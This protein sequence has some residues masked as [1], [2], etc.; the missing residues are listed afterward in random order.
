MPDCVQAR[1]EQSPCNER[2]LHSLRGQV[3]R[4]GPNQ[5]VVGHTIHQI[6]PRLSMQTKFLRVRCEFYFIYLFLHCLLPFSSMVE[7]CLA[8]LISCIHVGPSFYQLSD[9]RYVST[10]GR[11]YQSIGHLSLDRSYTG[12]A[13][14]MH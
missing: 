7:S 12:L 10:L 6:Q 8:E 9:T 3:Q 11:R 5:C 2:K 4:A 1:L 13:W 14:G